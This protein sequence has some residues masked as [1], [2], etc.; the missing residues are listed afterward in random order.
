MFLNKF[1]R[2]NLG[3]FPTRLERLDAISKFMGGPE[4]WIKRDDCTGLATGGNKTR[5]LEFLI[6]DAIKHNADTI[7]TQGATQSNH[8]RQTAAAA[9]RHGMMCMGLL[10]TR[11]P[12]LGPAYEL[13]GNVFLDEL[14]ECRLESR[15]AGLDMNREAE[16]EAEKL[17]SEGKLVYV[18]P[19]GGSN[20]IGAMG[21]VR[22]MFELAGQL[23]AENLAIDA[24]VH[25]TGSAGTQAGL[26]AGA[27]LLGRSIPVI[28]VSVRADREK[29]VANVK[30]LTKQTLSL[31]G[32]EPSDLRDETVIAVDDQVGPG[33]GY[34]TDE[35][36]SAIR[37]MA[38]MEGILL[39]PVYSGKGFAGLIAMINRGEFRSGERVVFLHTGG[40]AALPGYEEIFRNHRSKINIDKIFSNKIVNFMSNSL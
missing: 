19:G 31:M 28:G 29:Q 21:Y 18:I 32:L 24:L 34:P 9:A 27:Q 22:C 39:D 40:S 38:N 14:F 36:I 12:D 7:I 16:I 23:D 11:V 15:P 5:K 6:A 33:Y 20:P 13:S 10:E 4:I 30:R 8:V 2:V 17:R 3:H 25:A 26:L 1:P 35:T 37:L